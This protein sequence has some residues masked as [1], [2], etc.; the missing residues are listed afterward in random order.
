MPIII[1]L[2]DD[3]DTAS[4]D[5][6]DEHILLL[7]AARHHLDV[8][9][10]ESLACFE[11]RDGPSLGGY[12]SL[13]AYLRHRV[14]IA[15]G[16]ASRYVSMAR[17]ARKFRATLASWRHRQITTDQAEMLFRAARRLP[18]KY[19]AAEHVLLEIVGDSADET[20]RMLGYWTR[21]VDEGT[22]G[23]AAQLQRRRLDYGRRPNGMIEGGF[24]LTETAGEAF[25]AA[26]DAAMPPAGPGDDRSPP[27]R[28]HDA[29]ED[30]VRDF[31]LGDT[32]AD[33]GGERP[34]VN[35]MVDVAA[36]EGVA[37]GLHQT[38]A[39]RVLDTETIRTLACDSSVARI[40][41]KGES[42]I[43]DVGRR[44]RVVPT[45]LRRAVIA[46]DR[47]CVWRGCNRPPRWCDVHHII[48][49][50]DGGETSLGNLCLLCRYHHTLLHDH[51]GDPAEVLDVQVPEPVGARPI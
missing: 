39:G 12:P 38:E 33:V 3:K 42:E 43:L 51:Q 7:E 46:R 41:W 1:P 2:L 23:P 17:A 13:V 21:Q 28:R 29:L 25:I 27:Q 30:L 16:R 20:D 11:V 49:W 31:L 18:D 8:E 50:A 15:A 47:H 14:R 4:V 32:P 19:P 44:T 40:V 36:L 5:E 22:V 35:V 48:S 6:L 10:T 26:L 34:H 37:G 45:A 9:W 24:A